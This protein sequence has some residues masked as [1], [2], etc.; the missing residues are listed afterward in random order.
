MWQGEIRAIVNRDDGVGIEMRVRRK[1]VHFAV[2]HVRGP[3]HWLHRIHVASKRKKIRVVG[4]A[5]LVALE[6]PAW[7]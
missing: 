6:V 4:D 7:P 1:V 5:P 3:P 2:L